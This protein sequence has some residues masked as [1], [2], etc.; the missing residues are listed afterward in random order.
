MTRD[1]RLALALWL[2]IRNGDQR[3]LLKIGQRG[4]CWLNRVTG[5][6]SAVIEY[7]KAKAEKYGRDESDGS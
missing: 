5:V 1:E 2:N 3:Q 6:R 7:E 4:V